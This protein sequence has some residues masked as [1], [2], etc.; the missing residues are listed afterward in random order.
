MD[1]SGGHCINSGGIMKSKLDQ[2]QRRLK[3]ADN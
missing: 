1:S 3:R 2:W